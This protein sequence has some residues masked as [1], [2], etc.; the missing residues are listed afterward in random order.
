MKKLRLILWIIIGTALLLVALGF[1]FERWVHASFA[2]DIYDAANDVPDAPQPRVALVFGAGLWPGN[3]PSP[4]L[5]DRI[6]TAVQL[7]KLGKVEKLLLSGDNRFLNYNEP[8]VM[9]E[10]ALDMGVP[11]QD[12]VLDYAGRR[13]YDTCYRAREIFGV[14]HAVLVTQNFHLDRAMYLCSSLG[15]NSV[16]VTADH[17][18]Y[19]NQSRFWWSTREKGAIFMAW[20]D[21]HLLHPSPVL[22]DK[23]PIDLSRRD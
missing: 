7:Y 5:Y 15:V 9:K 2:R 16:G 14:E 17:Q 4:I 12:I 23:M 19:P 8:A 6:A 11:E 22:G 18:E 3:R 1:S 10:T 21:L 20:V 13:T